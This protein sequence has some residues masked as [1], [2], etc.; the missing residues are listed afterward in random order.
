MN[1]W[2]TLGE[3][4]QKELDRSIETVLLCLLET[5]TSGKACIAEENLG[6]FTPTLMFEPDTA[7]NS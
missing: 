7:N 2:K 1:A 3:P 4:V 6:M 5:G